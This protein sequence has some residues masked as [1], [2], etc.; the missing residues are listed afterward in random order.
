MRAGSLRYPIII[1]KPVA[2][3]NEYGATTNSW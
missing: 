3:K 1:Q 2:I